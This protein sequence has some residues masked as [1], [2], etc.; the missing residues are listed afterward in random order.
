VATITGRF[1]RWSGTLWLGPSGLAGGKVDVRIETESVDTH[2]PQRDAHLRSADFFDCARY[3][4]MTF[5]SQWIEPNAAGSFDMVGDL[6]I[7]GV[8]AEVLLEVKDGGRV[9]DADGRQRAGFLART[10]IDR[11]DFG[12]GWNQRTESGGVVV[13]EEVEIVLEIEARRALA[14]PASAG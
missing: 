14:A 3:P 2:E 8:S 6:T 10:V 4:A 9:V 7:R 12:L 11:R 1:S 13:G 5:R